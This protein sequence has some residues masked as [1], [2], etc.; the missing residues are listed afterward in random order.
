MGREI[1]TQFDALIKM[2]FE[3][4]DHVQI[5]PNELLP[6][7]PEEIPGMILPQVEEKPIE[8]TMKKSQTSFDSYL[9]PKRQTFESTAL[10]TASIPLPPHQS[11]RTNGKLTITRKNPSNRALDNGDVFDVQ[12]GSSNF[13]PSASRDP[14]FSSLSEFSSQR[15]LARTIERQ[16][17]DINV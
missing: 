16:P 12:H 17:E 15:L 9:M 5:A 11:Q 8:L 10:S 7:I 13:Y 1:S 4:S 3:A 14:S 6:T 2:P